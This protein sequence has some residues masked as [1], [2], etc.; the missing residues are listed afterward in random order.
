MR[1]GVY[2]DFAYRRTD[3]GLETDQAFVLFAAALRAHADRLVLIGR[4]DPSRERWHHRVPDGVD[5][6]ALPHYASLSDP[7][8]ALRTAIRSLQAFWRAL[9]DL[10]AV[11][12]LGP[13]P[14]SIAFAV[15]ARARGR[16]V[17]L[18]VRQRLPDYVRHRHPGRR[19]LLAAAVS[20]E[21]AFRTLAVALPVVAVGPDIART[22]RRSRRLLAVPVS[23]VTDAD[24]ARRAPGLAWDGRL[25]ALS[26]GRLDAEKN[27]LLLADVLA[28]LA[29]RWRLS[30]C[31]D[32][33][34]AGELAARLA[35]LGVAERADLRGYV[36]PDSGLREAYATAHALLH[37]SW[38]EGFP[39][40][41]IEAF[42]AGLPVVATDVGGVRDVAADAA[43]LVP[44]GDA[45]AAAAALE[46]LSR[47]AALRERLVAAGRAIAAEHTLDATAGRV[48][49]FLAAGSRLRSRGAAEGSRAR[50]SDPRGRR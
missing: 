10:D 38:T 34:L 1:L 40:V 28:A 11:W 45:R 19:G 49:A 16:T 4:L 15:L 32:G 27:P 35:R 9:D 29:D 13:H 31:G 21:A 3:R 25:T 46:R 50:A 43:L 41:L 12:L 18:G 20:L 39:Q 22:Y 2:A 44:P 14:Y 48:A 7:V 30:V 37:V 42:A 26:V 47:D 17:V 33:A 5:F 6:A 36:A 24:V 8:A 23:L